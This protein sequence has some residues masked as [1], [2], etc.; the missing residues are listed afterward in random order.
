MSRAAGH[1]RGSSAGSAESASKIGF[2]TRIAVMQTWESVAFHGAH[3]LQ[4]FPFGT[5]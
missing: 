1:Q 4:T 3:P 5:R 2:S